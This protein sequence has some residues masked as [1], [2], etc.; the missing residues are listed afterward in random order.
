M[1]GHNA[2]AKFRDVVDGTSN[3]AMV[4]ETLR[5]HWNGT[6]PKW[7]HAQWPG[8]GIDLAYTPWAASGE[9]SAINNH[10]C[11]PWSTWGNGLKTRLSDWSQGGSMH[12]GGCQVT[13]GD[14]SVR[15]ISE[16]TDKLVFVRLAYI[17]DGNPIELP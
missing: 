7:G 17:S 15:F 12:P 10:R 5:D 16:T 4:V 11:C 14:A 13:L 9:T 6:A 8:N 3:A 1:F 2:T